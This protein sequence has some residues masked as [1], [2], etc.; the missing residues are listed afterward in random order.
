V[1]LK[2]LSQTTYFVALLAV[3][4]VIVSWALAEPVFGTVMDTPVVQ[5]VLRQVV[6]PLFRSV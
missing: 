2:P 5:D 6:V 3:S 4:A 1:P